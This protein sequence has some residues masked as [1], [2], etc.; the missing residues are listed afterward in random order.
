M[1]RID[2]PWIGA[3]RCAAAPYD[4]KSASREEFPTVSATASSQGTTTWPQQIGQ[5][6]GAI[7]RGLVG[8]GVLALVYQLVHWSG[9]V[10]ARVLPSI[11]AVLA[12]MWRLMTDREF[13][14]AVMETVWPALIGLL[15]ACLLGI[16]VGL[17]LGISPLAERISRGL[18]D[19]L[20]S[21][22]G[23]ALIPVFMITIGTGDLMK[24]I[25]VVFVGVWPILFNTMYGIT[26]VD[27]VAI[28]SALSCR[29]TGPALWRRVML[30]S[31]APFIATG[32]RYALPIAIVIV[33]ADELVV[34][35]PEGIGGYLLQQQTNIV[36]RPE[37]I[38]AVLL[39]AG[40]V[41]FVLNLAMDAL[42]ERF[43]GWDM[44]RSEQT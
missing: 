12:E 44:R 20:R 39:A 5:W 26:S 21:L 33:I 10:D 11:L 6:L 7:A 41:G 38:Y 24:V 13:M 27:K 4:V 30:P 34:G 37:A 31:A 15:G 3:V 16:P 36:W 8:A 19:V 22:P 43:V 40:V 35:S 17:A 32:I 42:C 29:V 2:P 18:V 25:L 14:W 23:T 9:V 28:E 1:A